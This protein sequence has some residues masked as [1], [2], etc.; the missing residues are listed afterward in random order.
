MLNIAVSR[1]TEEHAD[2]AKAS[3]ELLQDLGLRLTA[4][5]KR[6]AE[7]RRTVLDGEYRRPEKQGKDGS[8]I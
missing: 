7:S 5:Q 3:R 8:S 4:E 1:F 6:A 2:E